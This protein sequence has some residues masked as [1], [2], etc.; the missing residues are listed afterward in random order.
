MSSHRPRRTRAERLSTSLSPGYAAVSAPPSRLTSY[1]SCCTFSSVRQLAATSSCNL[2][3][4]AGKTGSKLWSTWATRGLTKS[5]HS[6]QQSI[7]FHNSDMW[8]VI[9][10]TSFFKHSKKDMLTPLLLVWFS[11]ALDL[12]WPL[13]TLGNVKAT[14]QNATKS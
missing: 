4:A 3:K 5:L 13:K 10:S 11:L 7:D 14:G 1:L 9:Q 8:S 6:A 2:C 12:I